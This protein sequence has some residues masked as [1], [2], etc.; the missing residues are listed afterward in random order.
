MIEGQQDKKAQQGNDSPKRGRL[1][2][3]AA[4]LDNKLHSLVSYQLLLSPLLLLLANEAIDPCWS[5][6]RIAQIAISAELANLL[7]VATVVL[8][9]ALL[10][11]LLKLRKQ[12]NINK[13]LTKNLNPP[14][15][16]NGLNSAHFV[17]IANAS[18]R[19][20]FDWY[21]LH[22]ALQNAQERLKIQF[23]AFPLPSYSWKAVESDFILTALN[24][25]ARACV[26]LNSCDWLNQP[27]SILLSAQPHIQQNLQ[28]CFDEQSSFQHQVEIAPCALFGI[29]ET[30]TARLLNITYVFFAPNRAVLHIEDMT[31]RDLVEQE[32]TQQLHY[33]SA[34]ARLGQQ[35]LAETDLSVLLAEVSQLVSQT[36]D[37]EYVKV[38]ELLPNESLFLLRA[39]T[40]WPKAM[41]D[42]TLSADN[43]S[44]AGYALRSPT[45]VVIE[46]LRAETRFRSTPLLFNHGI[47]S[48]I[49]VKIQG[50]SK[51][52]G[53]LCVYSRDVRHYRLR[54]VEFLQSIANIL[55]A[56]LERHKIEAELNLMKRAIDAS[57]NGIVISDAVA[58]NN[59]AIYVNQSFEEMTGY[60]AEEI[61]GRNC[62]FLQ[63]S[64]TDQPGLQVLRQALTEG[65]D[66][67]TVLRN[68][69]KDGS[70]FWN[71]LYIAPVHNEQGYLTHFIGIQS[72]ISE[73]K[74][75]EA[76]R[77]R[78]FTLSL[79]ML[80]IANFEGQFIRLN[81]AWEKTLGYSESELRQMNF[82][83]RVHPDDLERTLAAVERLK[84]GQ[85]LTNF[86]HR[87]QAANGEYQW[88]AWTA[89]PCLEDGLIYAVARDI[90]AKKQ[91]EENLH[92]QALIVELIY[93]AIVAIALDGTILDWNPGAERIFGYAKAD[94]IGQS[95]AL[96]SK[97]Q[98]QI[99]F[100]GDIL[101][102]LET[103]GRWSGELEFS[104]PDS[105]IRVCETTVVPLCNDRGEAIAAISVS[106]DITQRKEAEIALRN[107]RDLLNGIMQTSVAAITVVDA[108]G[109]IIFANDRAEAILGVPKAE[110]KQLSTN[111]NQWQIADFAGNPLA[112]EH[113]P[114]VQVMKTG[115]PIFNSQHA[116]IAAN[117]DRKYLSINGSP[118]KDETGA[119]AGVVF[120]VSDISQHHCA[121]VALR[122]SEER[123][124]TIIAA[125]SD[126]AIV[127][128]QNGKIC[129][130]NPAAEILF[131]R[132]T[133]SLIGISFSELYDAREAAEIAIHHPNGQTPIAEMRV[134]KMT[135]DNQ[136]AYLASLRDVSERH[137]AEAALKK[138]EEQFRLLFE[139]APTGMALVSLDYRFQR[140]NQALGHALSLSPE[141][142]LGR[143]VADFSHTQDWH[144]HAEECQRLLQG[145]ISH[146]QM[147]KRY[148]ARD[149]RIINMLLQV[150]LARDA[151][152]RPL[153]FIYQMVD[154]TERKRAEAQLEYN[155][156]YDAL[157]DLPNRT[158]FMERLAH[159]IRR[160]QRRGSYLFAVLFLD[161][162]Y[163]KV[164]NDSL[165]HSIGDRLLVA[166]ARRLEACLRPSDTLAR[167]GGDEFTILLDSLSD[168]KIATN[169]AH[170][171]QQQIQRPFNLEGHEVFTNTS[172]G[173]AFNSLDYSQ[174]EEMLRDADTAMYRAKELG[175][176]R[177]AVFTQNMHASVLE[178]LQL[179]TDLRRA[180]E[181]QEILAY[182]QPIA[183][184]E[185]GQLIGFE[186]L[187]R[188]QHP[189]RGLVSPAEFIPI[190]EETGLIVPLG[191]WILREA[192]SQLRRWQQQF[193]NS[194]DLKISVNLSGKQ[195][196][197]TNLAEEIRLILHETQLPGSALK[198]EITETLLMDNAQAAAKI[199]S[200]LQ[201]MGINLCIDDFGTGY[202]SLS[203]LH[204]FPLNTLKIDRSFVRNLDSKTMAGEGQNLQSNLEIVQA[205]VTLAHTLGMD[206]IAEGIETLEQLEQLKA[207]GCEYGQG[208]FFAKP[209]TVEATEKLLATLSL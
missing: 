61:L 37:V 207:L 17:P 173:I 124:S 2:A 22:Q 203:Y 5:E 102:A 141:D 68:Y 176:G 75:A 74:Q 158:L 145:L 76:E 152:D 12:R 86:E 189:E 164:I 183:C 65:R 50:S 109:N 137:R 64:E 190:A 52:F 150:A 181:R 194:S 90:T 179:E 119:I 126:A 23:Q 93:D 48:G 9:S 142:L 202:S 49:S 154:I 43:R 77:D 191:Q 169:I 31:K 73:R 199:L 78:F 14:S 111:N 57:R 121:E 205:I 105:T 178:R 60:Q 82:P 11:L 25:A 54:E 188:W 26:P 129:F 148:I 40:G 108:M 155:A 171:I 192:C 161:L 133:Q 28:R 131:A 20:S 59:P 95:I 58:G 38:L 97:G 69:R 89:A 19:D 123:L 193:A 174:P 94:V 66:C 67:H 42:I 80:C 209:L 99:D 201:A 185:T 63:G 56:A 195:L 120:S 184:L 70:I 21:A 79:D 163:F 34:L 51:P 180:L 3:K 96:F 91:A 36:L 130:V 39:G 35:G 166:I 87:Y 13:A 125:I 117:G 135:W 81:P 116:L 118:L 29:A 172:I 47:L 100:H 204:R 15:T 83:E 134:V 177:Y 46:D 101:P 72:D 144:L 139:L 24:D 53:V 55:S 151:Q 168:I 206:A 107:E 127:I 149:G 197:E 32:L 85:S 114:F 208:Y 146:F 196:K 27:A 156:F 187:A 140:V 186:A 162:D 132:P 88:L 16:A 4:R 62:R 8:F 6:N 7:L 112:D 153:H 157:T 159:T 41:A 18:E 104:R 138:S 84:Q 128:D 143:A 30:E 33:S 165:G 106:H 113:L 115:K 198:L 200:Q 92:K 167:L 182:Y 110:L 103:Q 98:Q 71:E 147:E 45:A 10:C 44:P 136:P 1:L 122:E 170:E 160:S 175:K